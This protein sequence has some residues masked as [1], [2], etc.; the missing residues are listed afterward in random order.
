MVSENYGRPLANNCGCPVFSVVEQ[1]E[2]LACL[3][4]TVDPRFCGPLFDVPFCRHPC[5][6]TNIE[7]DGINGSHW[8]VS[9]ARV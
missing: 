2:Q 3:K 4:W 7:Q 8:V 6:V 5:R 1:V 9:R